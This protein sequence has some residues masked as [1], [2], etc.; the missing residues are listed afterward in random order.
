MCFS[1]V[2]ASAGLLRA[3]A[4]A[5]IPFAGWSFCRGATTSLGEIRD[6]SSVDGSVPAG[7]TDKI[8]GARMSAAVHSVQER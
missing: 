4:T 2:E 1:C 8:A 3:S 7:F 6:R 5:R